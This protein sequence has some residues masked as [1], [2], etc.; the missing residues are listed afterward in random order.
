MCPEIFLLSNPTI[1]IWVPIPS[2]L[3]QLT[4]LLFQVASHFNLHP[5]Y[6]QLPCHSQREDHAI[7]SSVH[8]CAMMASHCSDP[9]LHSCVTRGSSSAIQMACFSSLDV[10]LRTWHPKCSFWSTVTWHT[11]TWSLSSSHLDQFPLPNLR[12]PGD[13][14]KVLVHY[15]L[16]RFPDYSP[17]KS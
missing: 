17:L 7:T 10:F 16:V 8:R 5:S 11:P 13:F 14:H 4:A 9:S 3:G 12:H 6:C 15:L 2:P 1:V